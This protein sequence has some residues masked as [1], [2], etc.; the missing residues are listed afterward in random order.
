MES[1]VNSYNIS[2]YFEE[3]FTARYGD[4]SYSSEDEWMSGL[5]L[6]DNEEKILSSG[7]NHCTSNMH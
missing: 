3:D 7:S 1:K 4:V 6:Y 2:N 5:E